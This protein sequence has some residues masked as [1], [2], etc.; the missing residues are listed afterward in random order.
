MLKHLQKVR[1]RNYVILAIITAGYLFTTKCTSPG[2]SPAAAISDNEGRLF[3]GSASCMP[4]HKD[5]C[6]SHAATAHYH[7]SRPAS[8]AS[9]RGS[10]DSGRNRFIYN[11][12][13][14]VVM[15]HRG[16]R[17]Y[18]ALFHN[19]KE[20]IR[21]P[22]DIVIGSGRKGQ[23]YLYWGDDQNLFQLPVSYFT[24]T[25]SW[26][27]SPGLNTDD[28]DF[29]RP[30][31]GFCLD[32][33]ATFA[34]ALPRDGNPVGERFDKGGIIYGIDCEKCH[35]PGEEHETYHQAHPGESTGRFILN[36]AR[37]SRQQK[38]DA[39]ALCHSGWRQPIAPAFSFRT[40]DQLT[41]FSVSSH[42]Q[43]SASTLDVHG[44]QYGLLRSSKCFIGSAMDC[45]SCHNPHANESGNLKLYSRRCMSCHTAAA[46]NTCTMPPTPGL[47]LS[48]NCIDCH[49]P[50]LTTKKIILEMSR[51]SDSARNLSP[52][53]RTH[54]V[55]IYAANTKEYLE[56]LHLVAKPRS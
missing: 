10:F 13:S 36:A 26:A 39:C 15:Q 29:N 37:L 2:S 55:A 44:N 4:C 47:V 16:D 52:R 32:C 11:K 3:A 28:A 23:T 38:L 14:E 35:G 49:M 8:A 46:H 20:D 17:F 5:I 56:K 54:H 43:D 25:D 50:A 18:Q 48:D 53:V 40:G 19:G 34:K 41:R 6:S 12:S 1:K 30:I 33:H 45:S 24:P 51:A 31:A 21:R 22:F 7:D 27:N 9:I 42:S